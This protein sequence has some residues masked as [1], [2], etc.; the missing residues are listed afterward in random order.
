VPAVI[1][2][3]TWIHSV[4]CESSVLRIEFVDA[5]CSAEPERS[6]AILKYLIDQITAYAGW[7][8]RIVAVGGKY[9]LLQIVSE[10]SRVSCDRKIA[11]PSFT[12]I[13]DLR[14]SELFV[15]IIVCEGIAL[16]IIETQAAVF[17]SY[18]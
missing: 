2:L 1:S 8:R 17:G 5:H 7:R 10:Q 11:A 14:S 6:G 16:L 13:S 12:N 15:A 18:P 4:G 9:I 3:H